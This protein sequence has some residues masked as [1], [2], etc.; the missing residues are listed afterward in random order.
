MGLHTLARINNEIRAMW[1]LTDL[2]SGVLR[3]YDVLHSENYLYLVMEKGG[4][5]LFEF[6]NKHPA[7]A[8]EVG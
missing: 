2:R 8:P 3:L 6:L 1:L 4:R 5:D 7:G